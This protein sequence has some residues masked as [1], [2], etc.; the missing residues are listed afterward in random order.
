MNDKTKRVNKN[1]VL[2]I[3]EV[4]E[5]SFQS[6]L[7]LKVVKIKKSVVTDN[8]V[9]TDYL[10]NVDTTQSDR[11]AK[12][13]K[14]VET[15]FSNARAHALSLVANDTR[16]NVHDKSYVIEL[17][18]KSKRKND[19]NLYAVLRAICQFNY[20]VAKTT[21]KDVTTFNVIKT[22]NKK[23]VLNSCDVYKSYSSV[24]LT[25]NLINS[26]QHEYELQAIE[27]SLKAV[28]TSQNKLNYIQLDVETFES[29]KDLTDIQKKSLADKKDELSNVANQLIVK[30]KV[31]DYVKVASNRK[32]IK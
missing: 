23:Q 25:V 11:I 31:Y 7:N 30:Q 27:K 21:D 5:T 2:S 22:F 19:L 8:R 4:D 12:D 3:V 26:V 16:L 17:L 15:T 9:M 1:T 20:K 32:C 29:I 14:V 13:M 18:R 24:E 28:T 10:S 6:N